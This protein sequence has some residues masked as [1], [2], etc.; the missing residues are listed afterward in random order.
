MFFLDTILD[1]SVTA[2]RTMYCHEVEEQ[3]YQD[4]VFFALCLRFLKNALF[5]LSFYRSAWAKSSVIAGRLAGDPGLQ[6]SKVGVR[7]QGIQ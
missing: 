1:I 7:R 6:T 4:A 5:S 3:P 2:W